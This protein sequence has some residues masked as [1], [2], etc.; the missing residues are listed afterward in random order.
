MHNIPYKHY[1]TVTYTESIEVNRKKIVRS[2]GQLD[3]V[4][5]NVGHKHPS[6]LLLIFQISLGDADAVLKEF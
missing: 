4:S 3:F 6:M 1:R 5:E 2:F